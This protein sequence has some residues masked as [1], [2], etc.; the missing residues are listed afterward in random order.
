[1]Q[2]TV[3]LTMYGAKNE[4]QECPGAKGAGRCPQAPLFPLPH[5]RGKRQIPFHVR[6]VGHEKQV[7]FHLRDHL[8]M[9]IPGGK[10][11]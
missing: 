4:D 6:A 1:M 2:S 11:R 3:N 7:P 8:R 9:K 5:G 10:S